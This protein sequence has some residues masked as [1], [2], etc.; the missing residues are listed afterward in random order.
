MYWIA[1][2]LELYMGVAILIDPELDQDKP[3]DSYE[4]I[5]TRM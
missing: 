3:Y 4:E 1:T 2:Y 5:D